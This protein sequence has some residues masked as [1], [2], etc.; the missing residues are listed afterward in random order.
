MKFDNRHI[1]IGTYYLFKM[2]MILNKIRLIS[3]IKTDICPQLLG[4]VLVTNELCK[5]TND[6]VVDFNTIIEELSV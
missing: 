6:E 4:S 3:R 1:S 2:H 5:L